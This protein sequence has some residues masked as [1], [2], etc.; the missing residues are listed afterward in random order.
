MLEQEAADQWTERGAD[1]QRGGQDRHGPALLGGGEEAG[2][3]RHRH[4]HD[5]RARQ[6]H[7]GPGGDQCA[8]AVGQHADGGGE[9]EQGEAEGEGEAAAEAV[10]DQPGGE[11]HGG[12][13]HGVG[14]DD[15]LLLPGGGLELRGER[16]QGHVQDRHV[17]ADHQDAECDRDE[18]EPAPWVRP[19]RG[20]LIGGRGG[21][22]NLRGPAKGVSV[23]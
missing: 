10:A 6:A 22:G 9:A 17:E 3:H 15:P 1:G 5:E 14:V 20:R 2:D 18:G 7:R 16:G 23:K 13:H 12:E 21:H 19:G 11:H 8:R 4:R